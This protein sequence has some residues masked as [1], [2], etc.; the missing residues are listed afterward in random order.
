MMQR[1]GSYH[2]YFVDLF[3]RK[4]NVVATDLYVSSLPVYK[5]G[6]LSLLS[7][8]EHTMPCT[9]KTDRDLLYSCFL[10]VLLP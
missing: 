5:C 4:S 7:I 10:F 9:E 1:V 2:G 8:V 3:V 6:L